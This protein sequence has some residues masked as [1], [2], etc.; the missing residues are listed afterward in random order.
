MHTASVG[1][2][3]REC[4]SGSAQRSRAIFRRRSARFNSQ[5]ERPPATTVLVALNAVAFLATVIVGGGGIYD[6][7]ASGGGR[8]TVDYGLLAIGRAGPVF[9]GVAEG[10]WG[11]LV[12]GG[13]LHAGLLHLLVNMFLL[14]VL[15]RQLESAYGS[16]RFTG[17]YLSSLLA[18]SLGVML[19]D[20][21][22][23]TVGASGAVFGLMA[24]AVIY[25]LQRG[26]SPWSTGLGGL[27]IVN[28]VFTF[29]RPGISVG[30]HLG[31]LVG[32]AIV[33]WLVGIADARRFPRATVTAI[34]YLSGIAFAV[35]AV[36]AAGRWWDPVLG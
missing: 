29:G 21:Q 26:I 34:T 14:W 4:F 27:L 25:Q 15:G 8:V 12:T 13:F 18:G 1:F 22:A 24:A 17:L 16:V 31:G 32:G 6:R 36:L 7:F 33:A 28:V 10:E 9:I 5:N 19:R 20:P 35:A 30:G 11:R 2:H 23:L 3:C